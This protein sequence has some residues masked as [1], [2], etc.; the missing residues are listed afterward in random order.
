M[1]NR[2]EKNKSSWMK[3]KMK[4]KRKDK[5]H[6]F[7]SSIWMLILL[8]L[9]KHYLLYF[10]VCIIEFYGNRYL[11]ILPIF[12]QNLALS[13]FSKSINQMHLKKE[14]CNQMVQKQRIIAIKDIY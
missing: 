12:H 3:D 1:L 2:I 5:Y 9:K 7:I 10:A 14:K 6:F 4:Q 11:S 13:L 8:M